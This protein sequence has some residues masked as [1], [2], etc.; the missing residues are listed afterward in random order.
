MP[1]SEPEAAPAHGDQTRPPLLDVRGLRAGYRGVD[2]LH[3]VDLTVGEGEIVCVVGP[4]G[5]GKSTIFK[6]LY[7]LIDVREGTVLFDGEDITAYGPQQLL[8]AGIALVPQ[9][10]AIFPAM[11]V[12]ENIE[13]GM[14]L[15]RDRAKIRRRIDEVFDLFPKLAARRTQQAG[16]LSGGERRA[17]EIGRSLMLQPRLVLMDEPSVGL[18]PLLVR[19]VFEQLRSLRDAAGLTFLMIEQNARSG[20]ELS[21]RGYVIERGRVTYTGAGSELLADDEVRRT[22]LG[23]GKD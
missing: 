21:D 6:A 14:Y 13:L 1:I 15:E 22:F 20:L 3:G 9:L 18:S 11:T 10:P 7:G 16:T 17:L 19:E 23:V 12:Y 4:N 5:S 8:T 2:I